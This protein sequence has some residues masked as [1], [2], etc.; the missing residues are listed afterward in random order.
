[1]KPSV[2][3][4][5]GGQA[6]GD[7]PPA[8]K[9]YKHKHATH[10]LHPYTLTQVKPSAGKASGAQANG[11]AAPA[12]KAS[13]A[14]GKASAAGGTAKSSKPGTAVPK[15]DANT[16]KEMNA[17]LAQGGE[18]NVLILSCGV[19]VFACVCLLGFFLVASLL[20]SCKMSVGDTIVCL[21][22]DILHEL[23]RSSFE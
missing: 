17:R 1:M 11:D 5:S 22:S 14:S 6:N 10:M 4:A 18:L 8:S 3:E 2:G 13:K 16:L 23:T 7:G 12:S 20:T 15:P 19:F 21:H 9:S